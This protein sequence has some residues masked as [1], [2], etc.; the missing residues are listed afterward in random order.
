MIRRLHIC[1][2][3]A[4]LAAA[5]P[6][7]TPT[8]AAASPWTLARGAIALTISNDFQF[9]RREFLLT[10]EHQDFPV[11]GQ[12]LS[13]NLRGELRY[14]I[15]DSLEIGGQVALSYLAYE[16]DEVYLGPAPDQLDSFSEVRDNVLSF[17]RDAAGIGDLYLFLRQRLTDPGRFAL[18]LELNLKLPTGYQPPEGFAEGHLPQGTVNVLTL[19]DGQMDVTGLVLLGWAPPGGWLLRL[20]AGARLRLFG[21]GHQVV[22]ALKFGGRVTGTGAGDRLARRAGPR[23]QRQPRPLHRP[24]PRS[25]RV[26]GGGRVD[27][28]RQ[29]PGDRRQL[30]LHRLG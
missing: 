17:D 9:A 23:L 4:A 16:A 15:T 22:G 27:L 2:L 28:P 12:F 3:L 7:M 13:T 1:A 25:E 20:D 19:G 21:P 11:D 29:R 18:A 5:L 10:G 26:A 30:S 8:D 24:A 14:G 6:A